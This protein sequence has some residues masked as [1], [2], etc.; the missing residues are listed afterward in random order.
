M[1]LLREIRLIGASVRKDGTFL[2]AARTLLGS[3]T[4]ALAVVDEQQRV[5]GLFTDDDLLRGLFPRYLEELHHTAFLVEDGESLRGS[6]AK[7]AGDSVERHMRQ[8]V[9]VEI[10]AGAAH[11]VERFLHTP[12]GAVAVVESGR[13]VGMVNQLDVTRY[14]VE[15]LDPGSAF[16]EMG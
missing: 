5:V 11:V 13:F 15:R 4:S 12:W 16:L 1:A 6:L 14:L 8:P 3:E 9:T 7:A 2:E 10:D